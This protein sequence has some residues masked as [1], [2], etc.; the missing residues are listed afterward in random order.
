ML[1]RQW[2][3]TLQGGAL[4]IGAPLFY[5][6]SRIEIEPRVGPKSE[7]RW[8][9]LIESQEAIA[10]RIGP[11]RLVA[12]SGTAY[13]SW[14]YQLGDG[15]HHDQSHI[16][17]FRRD[18]RTLVSATRVYEAEMPVDTF[19]PSASSSFHRA[20]GTDFTIRVRLLPGNRVLLAPGCARQGSPAGQLV[21]VRRDDLKALYPWLDERLNSP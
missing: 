19:F 20:P 13:I 4:L 16:F 18:T 8:L 17:L 7:V 3:S 6:Q 1:P 10:R 9:D 21:L 15:D 2:L 12:E 11:P 5:A 14:H